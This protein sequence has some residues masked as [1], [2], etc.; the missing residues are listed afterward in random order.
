MDN[1]VSEKSDEESAN[2]DDDDSS[3]ARNVVVDR[4]DKL[5]SDDRVDGRPANACKHVENSD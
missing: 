2:G 1:L 3:V 4:I 5:S